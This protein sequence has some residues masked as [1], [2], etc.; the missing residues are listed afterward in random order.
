[1]EKYKIMQK[2][3]QEKRINPISTQTRYT[4]SRHQKEKRNDGTSEHRC[5]RAARHF[6]SRQE[7]IYL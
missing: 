4:H 6:Q 2:I 5:R 1:M 7:K 3:E